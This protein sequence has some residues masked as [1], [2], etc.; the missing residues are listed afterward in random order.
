MVC[1]V[2]QKPQYDQTVSFGIRFTNWYDSNKKDDTKL[3][4]IT[5]QVHYSRAFFVD[6]GFRNP[7][8]P[9]RYCE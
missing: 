8:A 7:E 5:K 6:A 4:R 2:T 9:V 1:S 3:G